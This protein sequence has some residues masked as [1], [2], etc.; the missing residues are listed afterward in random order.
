MLMAMEVEER[1]ARAM[2]GTP[3]VSPDLGVGAA[4]WEATAGEWTLIQ[5]ICVEGYEA[6]APPSER[7][8]YEGQILQKLCQPISH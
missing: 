2:A 4:L 1:A 3:M 5:C 6:G 7:P 8:M